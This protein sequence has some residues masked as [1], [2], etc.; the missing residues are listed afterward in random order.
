MYDMMY[1]EWDK[2]VVV[3]SCTLLEKDENLKSAHELI[4]WF[5]ECCLFS[6]RGEGNQVSP[7]HNNNNLKKKKYI[8][9]HVDVLTSL[10]PPPLCRDRC[11]ASFTKRNQIILIACI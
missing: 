11:T 9:S 8:D 5:F 10:F 2:D 1:L 6:P 4:D 7:G 3:F